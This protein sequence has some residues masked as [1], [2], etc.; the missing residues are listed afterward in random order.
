[1]FKVINKDTRTMSHFI[2][3]FSVC[4]VYF[5]RVLA[6]WEDIINSFHIVGIERDQWNLLG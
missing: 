2:P 4:I 5:E 6:S 1:M 3:C